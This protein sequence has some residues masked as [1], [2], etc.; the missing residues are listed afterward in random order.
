MKKL[1]KERL[2]DLRD[3]GRHAENLSFVTIN[4]NKIIHMLI[5]FY[6]IC[7][8]CIKCKKNKFC[9]RVENAIDPLASSN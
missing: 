4:E 1:D 6:L 7:A 3:V 2:E 5:A 8:V 9:Y